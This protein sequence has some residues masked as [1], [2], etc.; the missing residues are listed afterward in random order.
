MCLDPLY[1]GYVDDYLF[2]RLDIAEIE[3]HDNDKVEVN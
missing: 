3:I 2:I 1:F